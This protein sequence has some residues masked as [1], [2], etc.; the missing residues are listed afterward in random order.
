MCGEEPT[1]SSVRQ[2]GTSVSSKCINSKCTAEGLDRELPLEPR[3][4]DDV[5]L[6]EVLEHLS[7]EGEGRPGGA[8]W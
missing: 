5:E 7:P 2:S 8:S 1:L 4:E 3:V 6:C